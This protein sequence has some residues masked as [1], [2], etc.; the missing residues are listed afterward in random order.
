MEKNNGRPVDREA[1]R[2]RGS[3]ERTELLSPSAALTQALFN[4]SQHPN[5]DQHKP[6]YKLVYC[7]IHEIITHKHWKN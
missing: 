1:E 6:S 3:A 7:V 5:S 4:T 2:E